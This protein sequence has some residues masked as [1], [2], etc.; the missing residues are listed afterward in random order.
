MALTHAI[1]DMREEVHDLVTINHVDATRQAFVGLW[2]TFVAAPLIFGIDK[3]A[4]FITGDWEAY[5][6][7]WVNDVLPGTATDAVV[8]LGVVEILLAVTIAFVPRVGGDLFALYMVLMAFSLF[9]VGGGT[10]VILGMAAI[11]AAICA[12]AMARLSTTYNE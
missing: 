12:L 2:A 1:H 9:A 3:F 4:G 10:M 5:L 8:V 7:T 6:A 11:G